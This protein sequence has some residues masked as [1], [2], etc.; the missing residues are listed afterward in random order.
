[1]AEWAAQ[2][3][4]ASRAGDSSSSSVHVYNLHSQLVSR[5]LPPV[6]SNVVRLSSISILLCVPCDRLVSSQG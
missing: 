1:M 5:G 6:Q 4:H 3:P 2:L